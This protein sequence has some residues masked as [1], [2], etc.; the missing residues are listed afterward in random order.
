M[1]FLERFVVLI[2]R[3]TEFAFAFFNLTVG[4]KE[5]DGDFKIGL[6]KKKRA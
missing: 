2:Q 4:H 6:G 3:A 1:E 5:D